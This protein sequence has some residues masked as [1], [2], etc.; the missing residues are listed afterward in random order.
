M[1]PAYHA[2]HPRIKIS[3][4]TLGNSEVVLDALDRYVSD[5]WAWWRAAFPTSAIMQL[6]ARYPVIACPSMSATS[7]RQSAKRSSC[8]NLFGPA[9]DGTR[10]AGL[11]HASKALED[12]R[13]QGIAV[14]VAM[15]IGSAAALREAVARGLGIGTV[16]ESEYVP[17]PRLRPVRIEGDVVSTA[18]TCAAFARA[19]RQRR[20]IASF[21]ECAYRIARRPRRDPALGEN[22]G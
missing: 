19:A 16:S 21:F 1:I 17:D 22:D 11:D 20:L 2:V 10:S 6:Y 4:T 14:Q 7:V 8:A 5:A 3:V 13:Q 9:A 18:S 12:A 15:E